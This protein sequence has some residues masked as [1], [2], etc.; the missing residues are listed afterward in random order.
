MKKH[1]SQESRDD[2]LKRQYSITEAQYE[3]IAAKQNNR[4][5]ICHCQQHYQRLSVDHDHKT[6]MVRGLLCVQCNR[7]LGRFFDSPLRLRAAAD[8]VERANETWARV[9]QTQNTKTEV[10]NVAVGS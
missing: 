1:W 9:S 10:K 4:C 6:G 2:R 3:A 5:A 8:Y 7:G